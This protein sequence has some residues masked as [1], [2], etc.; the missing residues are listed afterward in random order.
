MENIL[1]SYSAIL[2]AT[3]ICFQGIGLW[4]VST[5]KQ[6][7]ENSRTSFDSMS[8]VSAIDYTKSIP[9]IFQKE[10]SIPQPHNSFNGDQVDFINFSQT[11]FLYL[12]TELKNKINLAKQVNFYFDIREL[13]FPSHFFW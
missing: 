12:K 13:I 7:S 6:T 1:K 2:L 4:D 10:L 8:N 5:K 9:L 3:L 11:T